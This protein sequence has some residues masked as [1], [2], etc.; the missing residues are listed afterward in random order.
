MITDASSAMHEISVIISNFNGAKYLPLLFATLKKQR[1]VKLEIIVVDRLSTDGSAEIL[2]HHPDFK[3]VSHTPLTGLVC[4]YHHGLALATKDFCFFMNEDMWLEPDCLSKCCELMQKHPRVAAVMPVQWTYDGKEIVNTGIWFTPCRWN[5]AC[6]SLRHRSYWHALQQPARVSYAN[7]GACLVRKSA[8]EEVGG[9]DISFFLDDEDTDMN[10]RFWQHGWESWVHPGAVVGHAVGASNS[11]EAAPGKPVSKQRYIGG[12]SNH[13]TLGLKS[14]SGPACVKPFLSWF[15][16]FF[17]NVLRGRWQLV[18]FDLQALL[19]TLAR[20]PD[21][22]AYRSLKRDVIRARPGQ[23][24]FDE[25]LFQKEAI[26]TNRAG[27]MNATC[28]AE[29]ALALLHSAS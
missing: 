3:V 25:P 5:R 26:S 6:P 10:L 12:L 11:K 28:E 18:S 13:M 27:R 16:R 4:G 22:A 2:A 1:G 24:F 15:E 9:W 14:F 20:L 29:E 8:Y 23:D 19:L 17:R 7:A 21:I